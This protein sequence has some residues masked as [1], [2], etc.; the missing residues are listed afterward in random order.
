MVMSDQQPQTVVEARGLSKRFG[1][2]T[3][4]NN[5]SLQIRRGEFLSLLGPSGCGKTTLLRI[6]A[7]FEHPSEGQLLIDGQDMAGRPAYSRNTNMIFQQL[8]LFPHMT[9]TQNLAFGLRMKKMDPGTIRTK[10]DEMLDLIQLNGFE[11]RMPDQLS[12]GQRQRVALARALVNSPDVLLLD[13]P[14]GALDLQ[15]R[16]QLQLELRR[17]QKA[18][19]RTFIF[20][21]HDQ[22][23]ALT[24]SDRI[25]VLNKGEI[26]QVGT[27]Q[28]IYEAPKV[29]FVA[30]FVGHSN[31]FEGSVLDTQ[32]TGYS[33]VQLNGGTETINCTSASALFPGQKVCVALR[34]ENIALLSPETSG[35]SIGEH[36]FG[37]VQERTYMGGYTRFLVRTNWG[38]EI[39][40]DVPL[41]V[42]S[43]SVD[44]GSPIQLRWSS[45]QV[46]ALTH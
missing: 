34:Y 19:N 15:L 30:S 37:T 2:T 29:R 22:T 1:T 16:L 5:I 31:L 28:E 3:V 6:I 4:L 26:V 46:I 35:A 21:T 18:L 12:G 45:S 13:E 43:Q 17:L 23:E 33:R 10:V 32:S 39:T 11:N 9:V 41:D 36:C 14:L 8:A 25:A 44:L 40:A 27:A 7:G 20:V 24:M 38:G 42:I